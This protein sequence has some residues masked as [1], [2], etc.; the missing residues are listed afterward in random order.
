MKRSRVI[1]VAQTAGTFTLGALAGSFLGI[2][3]APASGRTTRK[4]I[5]MKVKTLEH[6]TA[7]KIKQT[8]RILA[9]KAEGLREGALEKLGQTRDWLVERVNSTNGRK[10]SR[11]VAIH[12]A[13]R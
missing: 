10:P 3:F 4:W 11:K 9:R 2:L 8:R 12:H 5:G 1:A 7:R 13:S 6:Q